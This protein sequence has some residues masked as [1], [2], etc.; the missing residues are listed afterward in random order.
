MRWRMCIYCIVALSIL[1]GGNDKGGGIYL[2]AAERYN[3]VFMTKSEKKSAPI[4]L[5]KVFCKAE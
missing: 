3:E 1:V 5:K 2:K 4:I